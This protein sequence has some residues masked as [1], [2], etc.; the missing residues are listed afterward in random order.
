MIKK[1]NIHSFFLE[2]IKKTDFTYI[3]L[4]IKIN[5]KY[6]FDLNVS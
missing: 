2:R 6:S 3:L 4:N 1:K 5:K